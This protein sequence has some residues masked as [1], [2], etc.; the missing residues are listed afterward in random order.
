MKRALL[1]TLLLA[2]VFNIQAQKA[3]LKVV[4]FYQDPRDTYAVSNPKEDAVSSL[5]LCFNPNGSEYLL[6]HSVGYYRF[7][8]EKEWGPDQ[9]IPEFQSFETVGRGPI[10]FSKRCCHSSDSADN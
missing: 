1:I 3:Q 7:E 5:C 6:A 4:K 2:L 10:W 9:T 8:M